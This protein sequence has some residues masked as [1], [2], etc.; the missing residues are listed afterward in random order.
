MPQ[1]THL[2]TISA[3]MERLPEPDHAARDPQVIRARAAEL[4]HTLRWLPNS[5]SSHTFAERSRVLAHDFKPIF[6]ALELPA[7]EVPTFDDFR[8][9]YDN[10][11]LL[12][13]GLQN[14]ARTLQC[15]P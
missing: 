3:E 12:Y 10:R 2:K 5:P 15:P 11:R 6:A 8:W 13:M 7:P 1:N 14:A 9:L 4:A